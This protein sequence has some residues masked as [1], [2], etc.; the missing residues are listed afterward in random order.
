MSQ[1]DISHTN[2]IYEHTCCLCTSGLENEITWTV[3]VWYSLEYEFRKQSFNVDARHFLLL[4][5]LMLRSSDYMNSISFMIMIHNLTN[6]V[7]KIIMVS[8]H[9][10][11]TIIK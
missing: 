11:G 7:Q 5:A 6:L 4:A 2:F 10:K 8:M 9:Q 3:L 1:H